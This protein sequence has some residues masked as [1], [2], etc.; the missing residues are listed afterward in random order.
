M[1]HISH[2]LTAAPRRMA[3]ALAFS[4]VMALAAGTEAGV[5]RTPISTG[6]LAGYLESC[7][8]QGGDDQGN[9]NVPMMCC[10]TNSEGTKWCVACYAGTA[11]NPKDCSVTTPARAVVR[12][13]QTKAPTAGKVTT[14]PQRPLRAPLRLFPGI[15]APNNIVAP[16]N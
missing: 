9:W 12:S 3:A 11:E 16:N 15:I 8:L 4:A 10:A 6:Q 13:R 5:K 7:L 2:H 14:A 1:Q